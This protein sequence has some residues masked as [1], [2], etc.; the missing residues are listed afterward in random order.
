METKTIYH[1]A[2]M[3]AVSRR[4]VYANRARAA[5]DLYCSERTLSRYETGEAVPS[6]EVVQ[7]MVEAYGA[8]DLVAAHIHAECP[9]MRDYAAPGAAELA[10]AACAWMAVMDTVSD[11]ARAFAAVA[12]D[13]RIV[14]EEAATAAAIRAQAV[15]LARVMQETVAAIDKAMPPEGRG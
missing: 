2:R 6:C 7:L 1:R 13:G 11:G 15:A 10:Q 3:D 12:R 9:L 14:R 5:E 4:G 8:H